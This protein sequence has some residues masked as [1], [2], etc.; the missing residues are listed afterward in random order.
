MNIAIILSGGTGSRTGLNIPKQYY[1]VGEKPVISYC[2]SAFLKHEKI[3][4][5]QIVAD[6][7]WRGYIKQCILKLPD[8]QAEG[9]KLKGFSGPGANRQLSIYNALGDIKAYADDEDIVIVGD[10]VR[11]CVSAG[12]ISRCIEKM[13]GCDGVLPVLPMKDTVY[14]GDGNRVS[15]LLERKCVYAGQAPEAFRLGRYYEANRRL[16]PDKIL[17][18]SGSAEPA[19]MAG[20]KIVMT[21]GEESNFKITTAADLE[22][23]ETMCGGKGEA[24]YESV[25]T[26]GNQ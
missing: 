16:L 7:R 26:A 25:C 15:S 21:D 10:A 20:M 2:L 4:A 12:L 5:V 23:F 3:D 18:V 11:P 14:L 8:A 9:G 17:A 22:R 6:E 13:S 1:R 19:V 24:D